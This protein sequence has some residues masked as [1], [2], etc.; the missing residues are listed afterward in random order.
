MLQQLSVDNYILIPHL[1]LDFNKGFTC[2]T[3]E[4]G[5]GKSIL[6]GALSLLMG[7]RADTSV[8]REQT[9]KCIIEAT[10][11]ISSYKLES[12]FEKNELDYEH[13]CVFRR[14]INQQGKSRAFINDTP[15]NLAVMKEI[16][17]R[18]L[19]IHSQ[20]QT[21]ELNNSSFQTAIIDAY[22]QNNDLLSS[23]SLIYKNVNHLKQELVEKTSIEKQSAAEREYLQFQFD[24]LYNAKLIDNEQQEAE[25]ELNTLTHAEEIKGKTFA[26]L[27]LL[28]DDDSN[29]IA[30]LHEIQQLLEQASRYNS[31]LGELKTRIQESNIELKDIAAELQSQNNRIVYDKARIEVLNQRLDIIYKLEQ[32]HRV[33]SVTELLSLLE[34]INERLS[35]INSLEDDITKLKIKIA[36]QENELLQISTVLSKKRFNVVTNIEDQMQKLL[37]SLGMPSARF[38]IKIEQSNHFT[39]IGTDKIIFMFSANKGLETKEIQDIASGG[40]LSRLMLSVKSLVLN[41]SMLPTILFD[42]ID[43]GVSGDI[44][45]KVGSILRSMSQRMQ[46]IAITHLPQIAGK[47]NA[48]YMAY[49]TDNQDTTIS[50]MKLLSDDD[51]ILEIARMLSD[52]HV[53]ES[54]KNT[55]KEL[56]NF[57]N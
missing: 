53:T 20:H 51:R 5:A 1:E 31:S 14:E 50:S 41:Q 55:A 16:G 10:F 21:L 30:L 49:K 32:K 48:H 13:N 28:L 44:A 2:I 9:K 42:E 29:V 27:Q 35:L 34:S 17:A 3:G 4:T 15:V 33:S 24:E 7:Q 43:A 19:D 37:S 39:P 45:G 8:L 23:Y 6:V 11:E 56:L 38:E 47:A 46:V 25:A 26:A 18:L 12:L 36:E 57:K 40:E 22:A 52:E 54:A